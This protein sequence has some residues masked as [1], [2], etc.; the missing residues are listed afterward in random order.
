M[1]PT[2]SEVPQQRFRE[3]DQC[4]E[5]ER[6]VRRGATAAARRPPVASTLSKEIELFSGDV[7]TA[8]RRGALSPSARLALGA[9]IS[10]LAELLS[11]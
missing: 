6:A 2:S 8:L 9:L 10:T 1:R 3:P 5:L 11:E 4:R 7:R